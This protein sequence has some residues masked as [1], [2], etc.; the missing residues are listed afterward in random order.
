M[1]KLSQLLLLLVLFISVQQSY[2][3]LASII[4]KPDL[5]NTLD[6]VTDL[7]FG[8]DKNDALKKQN[9]SFVNNLF[10]IVDGDK[11]EDDKKLALKNLKKENEKNLTD[12]L[13][14]DNFKSYQKKMKKMLRPY[15]SK[16]KLLKF[17]L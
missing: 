7:G 14:V 4:P 13:G 16:M 2:A 17:A 9:E 3:Q 5:M 11:S 12:L 6:D 15:K 1:K 8:N 10:D